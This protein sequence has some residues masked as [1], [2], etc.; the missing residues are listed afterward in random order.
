MNSKELEEGFRL[1]FTELLHQQP[2]CLDRDVLREP[3]VKAV[4]KQ[5]YI[6]WYGEQTGEM[7]E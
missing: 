1:W 3:P 2:S 6:K 7:E 4:L 5:S